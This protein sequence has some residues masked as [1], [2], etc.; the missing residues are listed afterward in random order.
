MSLRDQFDRDVERSLVENFNRLYYGHA[1]RKQPWATLTW[2]GVPIYKCPEDLMMYQEILFRTRPDVIV[3]TG[4]ARG[5]SALFL[6]HMCELIG[7]GQVVTIDVGAAAAPQV[8]DHARIASTMVGSSTSDV[9]L[10]YVRRVTMDRTVMVILDSDHS[11][12]HVTRE[13]YL[14]APL[15]TE[16][17]Y[18]IVEDT[19]VNGHPV[20]PWHG[21][22]P[23]EAVEAFLR[24]HP[25]FRV[26]KNC[27]RL[28]VT[29]NPSGY[30]VKEKA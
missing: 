26:D 19:N 5:G 12:P 10:D 18:L 23:F 28:G 29:F 16:G 25:E 11:E 21:P 7:H 6:A 30:L 2:M 1:E 3:E 15:V 27:E 17:Q 4:T 24:G 9:I 14:Y 22:G 13:L 8:L 20:A